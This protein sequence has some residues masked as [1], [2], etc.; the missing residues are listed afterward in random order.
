MPSSWHKQFLQ[1]WPA[2]LVALCCAAML[3]VVSQLRQGEAVAREEEQVR[4][5]LAL[6]RSQLDA[7]IEA[8]FSVTG[9]LETL[10]RVQGGMSA[11]D[12]QAATE[13]LFKGQSALRSVVAAPNDVAQF[14][15]PLLGN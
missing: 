1:Y 2:L 4:Q 13:P 15:Y 14:V 6:A 12:F 10:L 3:N 7:V 9:S 8:T 11:K 5:S